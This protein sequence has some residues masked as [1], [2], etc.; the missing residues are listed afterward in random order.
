MTFV[1]ASSKMDPVVTYVSA[2][3]FLRITKR[4]GSAKWVA[5]I[6]SISSI[7]GEVIGEFDTLEEAIMVCNF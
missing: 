4:P 5:R 7:L 2:D 6:I 3:G 1:K